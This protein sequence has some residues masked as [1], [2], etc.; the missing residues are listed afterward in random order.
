MATLTTLTAQVRMNADVVGTNVVVTDAA[1]TQWLNDDA[2]W[3]Y[4]KAVSK[5]EDLY[6]E[7]ST[8][9][10]SSGN[11]ITMTNVLKLRK[12]ERLVDGTSSEY[13]RI[14]KCNLA[15]AHKPSRRVLFDGSTRLQYH[16]TGTKLYLLPAADAIGTYQLWTVP[17]YT[18]LASGSDV[19]VDVDGMIEFAVVGA[20]IKLL[21][22]QERETGEWRRRFEELKQRIQEELPNRDAAEP[23]TV[24]NTMRD[25][26]DEFGDGSTWR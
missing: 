4:E 24:V 1:I 3:F 15:D 26:D 5:Y 23:C 9:V 14:H 12:V 13:R 10:V 2:S 19:A 17:T 20:T 22:R 7:P 6:T 25:V 21:A 18:A 11:T 8:S 16:W